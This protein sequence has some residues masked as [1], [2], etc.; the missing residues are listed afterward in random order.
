MQETIEKYLAGKM[1]ETERSAFLKKLEEDPEFRAEYIRV[2]HLQSLLAISGRSGD[3]AYGQAGVLQF[4]QRVA[5]RRNRRSA[6]NWFKYVAAVAILIAGTWMLAMQYVA[7][8]AA[9]QYTKVEVP[10]GQCVNLTLADGS[11]VW[12]SPLSKMKIPNQF[13]RQKRT[14]ELDG[15]GYFDIVHDE[16][17]PFT[18]KAG[19]YDIQVLGT[20]F[21]VF[22]Y[23]KRADYFETCLVKGKVKVYNTMNKEDAVYLYP[24]EKVQL[25]NRQ[26]IK[27]KADPEDAICMQQG[28]FS[29]HMKSLKEILDYLNLWYDA[30]FTVHKSFNAD[31]RISGKFH[32]NSD[33]TGV[34][35]A[36]Q[37]IYG[38]NYREENENS[39]VIYQ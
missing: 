24:N 8:Q 2:K 29:F 12:L 36:L 34:L 23:S 32:Q 38:F 33:I 20:E 9:G 4:W 5:L 31:R 16:Q 15:E 26:L 22:A 11:H 1:D 19:A 39:Y 3:R 17:H 18:V 6:I 28:I 10:A 13:G 30:R 25:V 37:K 7:H 27:Q 14:V 21:K 35:D